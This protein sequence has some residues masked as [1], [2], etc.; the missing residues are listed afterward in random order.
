MITQFAHEFQKAD[1]QGR[2]NKKIHFFFKTLKMATVLFFFFAIEKKYIKKHLKT[3]LE[4]GLSS[5]LLI[6]KGEK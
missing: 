3:K 2:G 5:L 6:E 4:F 1:G